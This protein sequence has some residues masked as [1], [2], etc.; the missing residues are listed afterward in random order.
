MLNLFPIQWL[1]LFAY[2][3]LRVVVGGIFIYLGRTHLYNFSTLAAQLKLPLVSSQNGAL[4]LIIAT[5]FIIGSLLVIGLFTQAVAA[6]SVALCTKIIIWHPRFPHG[7]VPTRQTYLLLVAC[8][9]SL[10]IT[11][12]GVL[13]FDLPI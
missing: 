10:F 11:G 7:S 3:I 13:A 12:A 9:V 1:A 8:S 4:I 6:L 5:E 2:M